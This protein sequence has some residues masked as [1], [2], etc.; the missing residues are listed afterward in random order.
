MIDAMAQG[1]LA[2]LS[3]YHV[4]TGLIS[5]FAPG[6]ALSF[7]R[8]LYACNPVERRHLALVLKPWGALAVGMGVAGLF[9]AADP[10]RYFGVVV[11]I[12]LLLGLRIAYRAV[13]R[14]WLR[15]ISGI[16][17]HRNLISIAILAVGVVIL[18]AW[19]LTGGR[20]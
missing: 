1:Y 19:F 20:G 10:R 8:R 11:A 17:P 3:T 2:V 15:D 14:D 12:A 13:F 6:F 16:P 5:F 4:F 18:G 7:Y 9:A